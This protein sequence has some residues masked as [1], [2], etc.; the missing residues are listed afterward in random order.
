MIYIVSTVGTVVSALLGYHAVSAVLATLSVCMTTIIFCGLLSSLPREAMMLII[1]VLFIYAGICYLIF[2]SLDWMLSL[3]VCSV[4]VVASITFTISYI[5]RGKNRFP[6]ISAVESESRN[7]HLKGNYHTLFVIG[8]MFSSALLA[9][10]FEINL[11]YV[12][13]TLGSSVALAG[14]VSIFFIRHL[15]KEFKDFMLKTIGLA[16]LIFLVPLYFV[17]PEIKLVLIGVYLFYVTLNVIVLINAV[18]ETARFNMIAPIWLIGNQ[19]RIFFLGIAAGALLFGVFSAC[20]IFQEQTPAV[21]CIVGAIVAAYMQIRCNYQVYPF[22]SVINDDSDVQIEVGPEDN[23]VRGK[24]I[25]RKKYELACKQY[26]LSPREC[27][28]L[29]IL[30]KGRDTKYIMDE[31]TIS[32]ST[33]K[34]H[35]YNIYRKFGVHSRQDL[36]DTVEEISLDER[37]EHDTS[38]SENPDSC[39]GS[40][41]K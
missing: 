32:Q 23:S 25:W 22:E 26:K 4:I 13:M 3:I 12:F 10:S 6:Y 8:F 2:N 19:G 21:V 27:E 40:I 28:V 35:I 18:I 33:A 15:E 41:K 20:N 9:F 24:G 30:L 38:E 5:P 7:I 29:H 11:Q 31:F 36:L 37:E 16:S 39:D 14:V 34:T 1:D 17:S